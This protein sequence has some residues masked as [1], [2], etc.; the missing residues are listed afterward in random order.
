M[1]ARGAPVAP[2][3]AAEVE[4]AEDGL[5]GRCRQPLGRAR[6][7]E[8]HGGGGGAVGGKVTQGSP[9]RGGGGRWAELERGDMTPSR[10]SDSECGGWSGQCGREPRVPC[11]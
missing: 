6:C 1:N 3:L 11:G 7:S 9:S 8:S 10:R 2:H 5:C 4:R